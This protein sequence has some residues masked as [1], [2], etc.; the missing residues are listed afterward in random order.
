MPAA[1][2]AEFRARFPEFAIAEFS[3]AIV[4]VWI[5]AARRIHDHSLEAQH[6]LTAHLL[7]V[8]KEDGLLGDAP[9]APDGGRG[10]I[11][12]EQIG[13]KSVRYIAQAQRAGESFYTRTAYGRNYLPLRN[14]APGYALSAMVG[15]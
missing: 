4:T 6:F 15:G 3:D 7:T 2:P 10:E 11:D 9:P 12:T 1:T 5:A 8:A 14:A 13:P